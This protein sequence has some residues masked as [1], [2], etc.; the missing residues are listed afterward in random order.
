LGG[1]ELNR[2]LAIASQ[3]SFRYVAALPA[4]LLVVFGAVWL[5]DRARGGFK[6]VKIGD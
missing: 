6:A 3:T 1:D 5:Y 2:V 4:V